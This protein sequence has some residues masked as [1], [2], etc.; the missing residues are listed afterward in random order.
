MKRFKFSIPLMMGF[1]AFLLLGLGCSD[2]KKE[3]IPPAI[4]PPSTE[5]TVFCTLKAANFE[6]L[7]ASSQEETAAF[8]QTDETFAF[9]C[10]Y[11]S[12]Q[13]N[14][15]VAYCDS[16]G[17]VERICIE[18]KVFDMLYHQDNTKL[19]ILYN[20]NGKIDWIK[21]VENPYKKI[22]TRSE[23]GD[24]P[25][26]AIKVM[27][28]LSYAVYTIINS[29]PLYFSDKRIYAYIAKYS[30][31]P[32]ESQMAIEYIAN[33][34]GKEYGQVVGNHYAEI[35]SV[36]TDYSAWVT[37]ELYGEALPLVR[38][39]AEWTDNNSVN[40]KCFV[41]NVDSAKADFKIGIIIQE[42][43][44]TLF[45]S[46]HNIGNKGA[47][48]KADAVDYTFTFNGLE[49]G[50]KY[51][52][53]A[54]LAPLSSSKY[55]T[56]MKCLL[57]YYKYGQSK[58]FDL[59]EAKGE[60]KARG[61][62]HATI[63]LSAVTTDRQKI[64]MGLF[65]GKNPELPE[66]D[67]MRIECEIGFEDYVFSDKIT[68]A[69][70]LKDLTPEATYYYRP[71]I[72]YE[73]N[74][75]NRKLANLTDAISEKD[76]TFCGEIESF[77]LGSNALRDV[78]MRIYNECGGKNWEHQENWCSDVPVTEWEGIVKIAGGEGGD[79]YKDGTYVFEFMRLN[80]L[81]GVVTLENSDEM[82]QLVPNENL[83]GLVIKNCPKL[84]IEKSIYSSYPN[85]RTIYVDG[86][87]LYDKLQKTDVSTT[88]RALTFYFVGM[89]SLETIQIQ[90]CGGTL[91]GMSISSCPKL[92]AITLQN[93]R[94]DKEC[95]EYFTGSEVAIL[96]CID[97]IYCEKLKDVQCKDNRYTWSLKVAYCP[98]LDNVNIS[99]IAVHHDYVG[100][101]ACSINSLVYQP[102]SNDNGIDRGGVLQLGTK[103]IGVDYPDDLSI[104][105][106]HV[107][108]ASQIHYHH[109]IKH[110]KTLY[111]NHCNI[112][113][114][115]DF[116]N[117]EELETVEIINSGEFGSKMNFTGCPKLKE[118]I[119]QGSN[120][121]IID[122]RNCSNLRYADCSGNGQL[123]DILFDENIYNMNMNCT[124]NHKLL[125]MI[126]DF[127]NPYGLP[128]NSNRSFRYDKRY[129]YTWDKDNNPIVIDRKYGWWYPGEPQSRYHGRE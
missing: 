126:P 18:N 6:L 87:Q 25:Y 103:S 35:A 102:A 97:I 117:Y 112:Y 15:L 59:L 94:F 92:K 60:V 57:D 3:E 119:I 96:S 58:H 71:Y 31:P 101:Y 79:K 38:Q 4:T 91:L 14:R 49:T 26:S 33:I 32:L 116:S 29:Y 114:D 5:S 104:R 42:E 125:K 8:L 98:T 47:V 12:C 128:P 66:N 56:E 90:N 36:M 83:E 67:R 109:P 10:L 41:N 100:I 68:K 118:L 85:L 75:V 50:K 23:S 37:K 80:K 43:G 63:E 27:T 44:K 74:I 105:N 70:E 46:Q 22:P 54:Y 30:A 99:N 48:Y 65:Y 86:M 93:N 81:T 1:V 121:K 124:Y 62:D 19:D 24:V 129:L 52:F 115:C 53:K 72:I 84:Q 106:I 89:K 110:L 16:A 2:N 13:N 11:D 17:V 113:G 111:M 108:R 122:I 7:A 76:R 88:K 51:K 95:Y 55:L 34:F 107:G 21:D 45:S 39:Y 28:N 40:L 82:I 64:K 77:Q 69:I 78:V 20:N 123:T 9:H 120:A 61:T 73:G 127:Y